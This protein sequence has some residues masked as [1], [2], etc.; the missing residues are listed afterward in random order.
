MTPG[1]RIAIVGLAV[2]LPGAD[3]PEDFFDCLLAGKDLTTD[4]P[5]SRYGAA[6]SERIRHAD[7]AKR[8]GFLP[9]VD[10]FDAAF[11]RVSPVEACWMDPQQRL[12]LETA[13]RSLESSGYRPEDLPRETGVFVGV[14]G[15]DYASLLEAHDVPHDGFAATGNSLAMVANRISY[16]L[17]S[18]RC[19]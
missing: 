16:Y 9:A 4:F 14:S 15:R 3:Q 8:G 17:R 2:R 6:Y 7:F 19:E 10:R 1:C 18:S 11:F 13:W 5:Y 12:M